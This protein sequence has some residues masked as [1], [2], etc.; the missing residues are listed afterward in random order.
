MNNQKAQPLIPEDW[1]HM[2]KRS[3]CRCACHHSAEIIHFAPCCE[4]DYECETCR[5]DPMVCASIP[6][7]RHCAAATRHNERT[8]R[9]PTEDRK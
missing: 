8:A 6:G 9:A 4:A 7:L 3:Q 2:L 1:T 5:D